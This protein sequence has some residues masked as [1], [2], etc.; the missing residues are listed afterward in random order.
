MQTDERGVLLGSAHHTQASAANGG[1][2]TKRTRR[3]PQ[4]DPR[5]PPSPFPRN[6]GRVQTR[7]PARWGR[8]GGRRPLALLSQAALH[9]VYGTFKG[10]NKTANNSRRGRREPLTE[11]PPPRVTAALRRGDAAAAERPHH[12]AAPE[13]RRRR[14]S[15]R[16]AETMATFG[17][18][19]YGV[20]GDRMGSVPSARL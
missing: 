7:P 8:S 10:P 12:R 6:A 2:S 14:G 11:P 16:W 19:C 17:D 15:R 18:V 13:P 3:R 20:R 5:R 9:H 4:Q 1:R